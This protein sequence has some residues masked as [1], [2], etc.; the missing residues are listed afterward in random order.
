MYRCVAQSVEAFVQQ[1][2]VAYISRGYWFY[3]TGRVPDRKNP[4]LIEAMW[5]QHDRNPALKEFI[6]AMEQTR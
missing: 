4:A 2:A 3:V 1:L 6:A 5:R